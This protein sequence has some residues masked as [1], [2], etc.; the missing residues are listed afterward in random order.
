MGKKGAEDSWGP[1][2]AFNS[3]QARY[4]L[5]SEPCSSSA[6][7][8]PGD[9]QGS[10]ATS[11]AVSQHNSD[12]WI[13]VLVSTKREHLNPDRVYR[14]F[15]FVF[16]S[17]RK[18]FAVWIRD[19]SFFRKCSP[20]SSLAFNTGEEDGRKLCRVRAVRSEHNIQDSKKLQT[21]SARASQHRDPPKPQVRQQGHHR[22][23]GRTQLANEVYLYLR[24]DNQEGNAAKVVDSDIRHD[25]HSTRRSID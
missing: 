23:A 10:T 22:Y 9:T 8:R 18:G 21:V 11:L 1:V 25:R 14:V 15:R 4:R 5:C 24:R 19:S 3:H 20:F 17:V 2:M 12:L 13:D 6:L 7:A 16:C